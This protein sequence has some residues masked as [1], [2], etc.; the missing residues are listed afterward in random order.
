MVP[1]YKFLLEKEK[2]KNNI[3]NIDGEKILA[4]KIEKFNGYSDKKLRDEISVEITQKGVKGE[5]N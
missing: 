2:E 1:L 3:N 5:W 4:E